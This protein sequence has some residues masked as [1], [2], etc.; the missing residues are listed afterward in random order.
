MSV[1]HTCSSIRTHATRSYGPWR[2]GRAGLQLVPGSEQRHTTRPSATQRAPS[3]QGE[4]GGGR[5]GAEA[6]PA[7]GSGA[8]RPVP[9]QESNSPLTRGPA[10]GATSRPALP[11]L[12]RGAR[13]TDGRTRL[14][15][16]DGTGQD[17]TARPQAE[18]T[19]PRRVRNDRR[20]A[21]ARPPGHVAEAG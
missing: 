21:P 4:R 19:D 7:R 20:L 1:P 18:T 16:R 13:L 5:R 9:P 17:R 12:R 8:V 3:P 6:R 11:R 14:T 15:G 2:R 10:Q